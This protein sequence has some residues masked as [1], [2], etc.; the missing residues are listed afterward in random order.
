MRLSFLSIFIDR[1]QDPWDSGKKL[2]LFLV[3]ITS[4]HESYDTDDSKV[5]FLRIVDKK[6]LE[7]V[8]MLGI[9]LPG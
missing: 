4:K 5:S 2:F 9:S 6:M 8:F 3:T 1:Y 7:I